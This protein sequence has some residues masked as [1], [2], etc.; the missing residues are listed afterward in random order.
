MTGSTFNGISAM[1]WNGTHWVKFKLFPNIYNNFLAFL[2]AHNIYFLA[3][4]QLDFTK[5]PKSL[6]GYGVSRNLNEYISNNTE[7]NDLI[8]NFLNYFIVNIVDIRYKTGKKLNYLILA[9]TTWQNTKFVAQNSYIPPIT[10]T[11]T[12]TP[13]PTTTTTT[14]MLPTTTLSPT[15]TLPPISSYFEVFG[16]LYNF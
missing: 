5:I 4:M 2:S 14:T 15:T 6:H 1:C 10:T 16:Q 9:A 7:N 11:T 8:T 3:E 13:A 12:T